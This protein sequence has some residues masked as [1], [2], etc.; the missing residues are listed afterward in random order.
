MLKEIKMLHNKIIQ[1]RENEE[2]SRMREEQQ[3]SVRE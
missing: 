1:E 2:A 3:G